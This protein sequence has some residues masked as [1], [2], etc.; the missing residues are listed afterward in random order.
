MV[1]LGVEAAEVPVVDLVR[2]EE[3]ALKVP[4]VCRGRAKGAGQHSQRGDAAVDG[5]AAKVL[6]VQ[7][8]AEMLGE[9][10]GGRRAED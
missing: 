4:P 8:P 5:L 6:L 1:A 9:V 10:F 3:V 2:R 7:D